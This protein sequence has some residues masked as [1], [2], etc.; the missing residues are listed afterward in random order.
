MRCIILDTETTGL[1]PKQG[2]RV[3]EIAAV[4]VVDRRLTGR[5]I[6]FYVNPEREIDAGATSRGSATWPVNSSILPPAR[7]GSSTTR[8]ST[9]RSST[10]NCAARTCHRL[11]P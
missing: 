4:E 10:K 2:H 3:I 5:H 8:R 1:D 7:A 6:H 11:R 9:S